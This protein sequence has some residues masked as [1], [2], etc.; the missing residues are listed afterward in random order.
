MNAYVRQRRAL[1]GQ[2]N[3]EFLKGTVVEKQAA[4]VLAQPVARP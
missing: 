4:D 2:G 3:P 1:L